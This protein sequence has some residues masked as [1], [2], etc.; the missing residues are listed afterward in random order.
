MT[1]PML[2]RLQ[3]KLATGR[4]SP[5][6]KTRAQIASDEQAQELA[7]LAVDEAGIGCAGDRVRCT[8]RDGLRLVAVVER[9]W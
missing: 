4:S 5:M 9:A 1:R 7:K 3:W 8:V 6:L 2:L